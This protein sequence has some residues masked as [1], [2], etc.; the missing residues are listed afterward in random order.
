MVE[1]QQGRLNEFGERGLV[2]IAFDANRMHM[3]RINQSRFLDKVSTMI[4]PFGLCPFNFC[5]LNNFS[6]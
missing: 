1:A 4:I 3:Q 2:D 5:Q 6:S